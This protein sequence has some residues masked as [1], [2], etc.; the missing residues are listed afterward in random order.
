[1]WPWSK[2]KDVDKKKMVSDKRDD[3]MLVYV[4]KVQPEKIGTVQIAGNLGRWDDIRDLQDDLIVPLQMKFGGGV[5]E[6]RFYDQ[7][8]EKQYVG[9]KRWKSPGPPKVNGRD[10]VEADEEE[11]DMGSGN[12]EV[13]KAL[14]EAEAVKAQEKLLEAKAN[15]EA[16]KRELQPGQEVVEDAGPVYDPND[17]LR[18]DLAELK[19]LFLKKNE[20]DER[21]REKAETERQWTA[22]FDRMAEENKRAREDTQKLIEQLASKKDDGGGN[23]MIEAMKLSSSASDKS[24]EKVMGLM[25]NIM[26]ERRDS[27]REMTTVFGK[28]IDMAMKARSGKMIGEDDEESMSA[29]EL[30]NNMTETLAT[31]V[32]NYILTKGDSKPDP[33]A[34]AAM[35]REGVAKAMGE[36][37]RLPNPVPPDA[38]AAPAPPAAM[39]PMTKAMDQVLMIA[40]REFKNHIDTKHQ[41]WMKRARDILPPS[42]LMEFGKCVG[43][44]DA[45]TALIKKYASPDL[46][47]ELEAAVKEAI[48]HDERVAEAAAQ[49]VAGAP[50]SAPAPA[51]AA[52]D[53]ALDGA[54]EPAAEDAG[55]AVD[56]GADPDGSTP[57]VTLPGGETN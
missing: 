13:K 22:R 21:K 18:A 40:I 8:N 24:N 48:Q 55:D 23:A 15:F 26:S 5:Y 30:A 47:E 51:E 42:M 20:E 53:E 25:T 38:P 44:E 34:M 12:P 43:D 9:Y 17:D 32:N 6:G 45:H 14:Q 27:S 3:P 37:M 28:G 10:V 49:R 29:M 54:D 36:S 57:T 50:A 1:M 11:D 41:T 16:R 31:I 33:K 2:G 19:Q 7:A 52:I 4:T 56:D 39:T 46:F 35:I